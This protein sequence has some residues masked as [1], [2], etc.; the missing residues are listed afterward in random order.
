[1]IVQV[2]VVDIYAQIAKTRATGPEIVLAL[3][4]L[5]TIVT[6]ASVKATV[7]GRWPTSD[8]AKMWGEVA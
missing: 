6:T 8:Y 2:H 7:V 4:G 1:L 5:R 3:M